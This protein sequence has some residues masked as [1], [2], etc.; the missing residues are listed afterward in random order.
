MNLLPDE[1][2]HGGCFQISQEIQWLD[3]ID[4]FS[5]TERSLMAIFLWYKAPNEVICKE[6]GKMIDIEAL[7]CIW[8]KNFFSSILQFYIHKNRF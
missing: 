3:Q 6:G 8:H 2:L 5:D 4:G 7:K 1:F